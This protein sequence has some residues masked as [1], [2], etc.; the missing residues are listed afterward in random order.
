M[1]ATA[2]KMAQAVPAPVP[3]RIRQ[4]QS[5]HR[6]RT[7]RAP[8]ARPRTP[9]PP[10]EDRRARRGSSPAF[11][12]LTAVI[13]TAMVVGVVSLS[14]LIVQASF[15]LDELKGAM[16]DLGETQQSLTKEVA[17]LSS[18]PR[19]MAWARRE[20]MVMPDEA[21]FVLRVRDRSG[22]IV[23]IPPEGPAEAQA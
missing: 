2:R 18:P 19:V 16:A 13:V 22:A 12:V 1:S 3:A 9:T 23:Q 17:E 14:A 7:T 6:A 15:R 8:A 20:G 21:P 10:Q 11:W 5:T 4:P